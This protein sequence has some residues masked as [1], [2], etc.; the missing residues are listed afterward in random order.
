MTAHKTNAHGRRLPR[1]PRPIAV[2]NLQI[3]TEGAAKIDPRQV[4]SVIDDLQATFKALREGVATRQQWDI[5]Y[6]QLDVAIAIEKQ[7]V[8]RGLREHFASAAA[9]LQTIYNRAHSAKGWTPTAL[10]FSELDALRAF[11]NLHA[12]QLRKLS[13]LEFEQVIKTATDKIRSAGG[14]VTVLRNLAGVAA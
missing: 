6:G 2:N 3:A 10:H 8:V 5:L 13:R 1:R 12:F 9:A 14:K 4:K 11:V 7:G